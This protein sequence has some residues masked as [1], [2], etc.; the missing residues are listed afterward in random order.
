MKEYIN[1][2]ANKNPA[3]RWIVA[4]DRGYTTFA[5]KLGI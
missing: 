5:L 4:E 1:V 3:L 2:P